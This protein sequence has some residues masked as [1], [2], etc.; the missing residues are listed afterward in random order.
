MEQCREAIRFYA[1]SSVRPLR[2]VKND[3]HKVRV[4]CGSGGKVEQKGLGKRKAENNKQKCVNAEDDVGEENGEK[5]GKKGKEKGKENR[6]VNCDWLL[7]ASYLGK[8][9]TTRI[10]TYQPKHSCRRMQKTKFATSYWLAQRFNEDLR[11]NPNMSVSN[12]MKIVRKNYGIDITANQFY[13]AKSIA[14]ERIHGS[15]EEQYAKLW[16]YCEELKTNNPGSTILIKTDL[17]GDNPVFKIIDICFGA[18]KKGFIAGCMPVVGFDGCHVKRTHPRQILSV[19]GIDAN[20]GMYPI[21]FVVVEV[22]NTK[23]WTWFMEIFFC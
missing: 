14:R 2:W 19:G 6:D 4:V 5:D 10:K 20:N 3:P 8:R 17:R 7:Y 18:L 13:K 12:F 15:I 9:H 11:D 1:V 22:E 16:D 21:A 23:T